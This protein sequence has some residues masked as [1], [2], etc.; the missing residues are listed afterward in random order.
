MTGKINEDFAEETEFFFK[1]RISLTLVLLFAG[2]ILSGI[3]KEIL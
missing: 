3:N 1:S 2:R